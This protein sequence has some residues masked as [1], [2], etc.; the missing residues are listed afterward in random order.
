MRQPAAVQV[1][2]AFTFHASALAPAWLAVAQASGKD[3][4]SPALSRTTLVEFHDSGTRLV[5][6]DGCLLLAAWV[7]LVEFDPEPDVHEAPTASVIAIDAHGRG[8][9]LMA[10][11]RKLAAQAE[12]DGAPAVEITFSVGK[13]PAEP[14]ATAEFE[15]LEQRALVVDHPG[16]EELALPLFE[17]QYPKWRGILATHKAQAPEAIALNPEIIGRLAKLGKFFDEPL[18]W[19]FGGSEGAALISIGPVY[20]A[21]MPMRWSGIDSAKV[22]KAAPDIEGAA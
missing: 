3:D 13:P 1:T 8:A 17:G 22:E 2:Q 5:A 4:E 6:T 10:H 11:L 21:A 9:G 20:G 16:R 12:K 19:R 7:P 14:N 18:V 15:G